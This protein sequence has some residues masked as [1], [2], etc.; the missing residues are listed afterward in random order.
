MVNVLLFASQVT[1]A[2]GAVQSQG[3][4]L[5]PTQVKDRPICLKWPTEK[6]ALYTLVMTDPDAPSRAAPTD[7]EFRHW[8][9]VNM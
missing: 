7:R 2:S 4:V 9:V 5:T 3:N 8:L 1:Y 6:G